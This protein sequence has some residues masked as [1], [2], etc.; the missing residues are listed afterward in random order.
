M[1]S[2]LPLHA[3]LSYDSFSGHALGK[4][5]DVQAIELTPQL[6]VSH[7]VTRHMISQLLFNK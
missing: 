6:Q 4:A 3:Y 7:W 2:L 5:E 1:L